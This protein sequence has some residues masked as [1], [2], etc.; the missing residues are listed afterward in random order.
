[1]KT[2]KT[3][4]EKFR[5]GII[6]PLNEKLTKSDLSRIVGGEDPVPPPPPIPPRGWVI[7][8]Y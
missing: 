4:N 6:V 3:K 7:P 5:E 8:L 1:M 2:K